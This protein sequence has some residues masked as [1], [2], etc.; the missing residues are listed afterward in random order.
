[1][2]SGFCMSDGREPRGA[3]VTAADIFTATSLKARWFVLRACETGIGRIHS[4]EGVMGLTLAPKYA[5]AQDLIESLWSVDDV[6]FGSHGLVL[7]R[8]IEGRRPARPARRPSADCASPAKA[9]WRTRFSGRRL[10]IGFER[11][12]PGHSPCCHG[13]TPLAERSSLMPIRH[14]NRLR[15]IRYGMVRLAACKRTPRTKT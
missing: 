3:L 5:G 15:F 13:T 4:G 14:L 11:A 6:S 8:F 9:I 10:P 12:V 2:L 1:M 7:R